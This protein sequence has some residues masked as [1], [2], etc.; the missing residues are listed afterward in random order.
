M[1]CHFALFRNRPQVGAVRDTTGVRKAVIAEKRGK[2]VGIALDQVPEW[3]GTSGRNTQAGCLRL[4]RAMHNLPER[5]RPLPGVPAGPGHVP[6]VRGSCSICLQDPRRRG[7]PSELVEGDAVHRDLAIRGHDSVIG[8]DLR[9]GP[10]IRDG[11]AQ[12]LH[13]KQKRQDLRVPF[14]RGQGDDGIQARNADPG[15]ARD[16]QPALQVDPEPAVRANF[17]CWPGDPETA[18]PSRGPGAAGKGLD[19][20]PSSFA[21]VPQSPAAETHP[22]RRRP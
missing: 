2:H 9:I 8:K 12:A 21:P 6:L 18:D 4:L 7:K 10:P 22:A 13:G 17:I 11:L 19:R 20:T 16:A 5:R 15:L 1:G 14:L 3:V